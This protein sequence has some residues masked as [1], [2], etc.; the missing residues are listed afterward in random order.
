M[1]EDDEVEEQKAAAGN[2][3]SRV[4][5]MRRRIEERLDSKRIAL[6]YDYLEMED[7]SEEIEEPWN[8]CSVRC[9][10]RCDRHQTGQGQ[11]VGIPNTLPP[12]AAATPPA[13]ILSLVPERSCL[14]V[15]HLFS[16]GLRA[17]IIGPAA[18]SRRP[19]NRRHLPGQ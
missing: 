2:A 7:Y 18:G 1:P 12:Q 4:T 6:E 13:A 9:Q 5:E 10:S 15:I 17:R 16:A 19:V 3:K 11:R 14:P 8:V